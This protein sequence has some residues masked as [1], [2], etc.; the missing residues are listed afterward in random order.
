MLLSLGNA[1]NE[2]YAEDFI[3][4]IDSFCNSRV[5]LEKLENKFMQKCLIKDR[6]MINLFSVASFSSY[7]CGL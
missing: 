6:M 7:T 2:R 4:S 1:R 3:L 5:R